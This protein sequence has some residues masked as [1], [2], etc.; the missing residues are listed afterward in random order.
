MVGTHYYPSA[1]SDETCHF[2]RSLGQEAGWEGNEIVNVRVA[3]SIQGQISPGHHCRGQGQLPLLRL[4]CGLAM[5]LFHRLH[6]LHFPVT[7]ASSLG[8]WK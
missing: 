7:E 3:C 8:G 6:K 2:S 4:S 1:L 5:A